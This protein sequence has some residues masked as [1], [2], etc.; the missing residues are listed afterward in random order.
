MKKL[1]PILFLW[2]SCATAVPYMD[3]VDVIEALPPVYREQAERN[4]QDPTCRPRYDDGIRS[5]LEGLEGLFDWQL[6]PQGFAYWDSLHHY[7]LTI[8]YYNRNLNRK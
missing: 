2:C 8:D 6:T 7:M 1:I 3:S 4:F 5:V